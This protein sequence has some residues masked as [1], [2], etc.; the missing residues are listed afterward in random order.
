L[1]GPIDVVAGSG[2]MNVE[3][4]RAVGSVGVRGL[5][6]ALDSHA[7]GVIV[8]RVEGELTLVSTAKLDVELSAFFDAGSCHTL[9]LDLAGVTVLDSSGLR[10]LWTIRHAMRESGG[11]LVLRS[12]SK[13][14]VHVLYAAGIEEQFE[15][16]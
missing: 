3:S 14:V 16:R 12:P 8:S 15:I 2:T 13:T 7:G 9:V 5:Q 10:A 1:K 11:R 4:G 6:V